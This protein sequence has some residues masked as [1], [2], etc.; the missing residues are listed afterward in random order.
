MAATAA[1]SEYVGVTLTAIDADWT[2]TDDVTENVY[3]NGIPVE[4]MIFIPGAASDKI[5]VL[6]VDANGTQ[7]FPLVEALGTQNPI[8]LYCRGK[9]LKPFIDFSESTLSSGATFIINFADRTR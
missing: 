5:A 6:E 2:W 1:Y 8:V 9:K 7:I 3:A 4:S